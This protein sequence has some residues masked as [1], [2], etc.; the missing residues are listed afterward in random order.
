LN[1]VKR[2]P[3]EPHDEADMPI[4]QEYLGN[5][6][7]ILRSKTLLV[8]TGNA[9][10]LHGFGYLHQCSEPFPIIAFFWQTL[11]YTQQLPLNKMRPNLSAT[12][13][14]LVEG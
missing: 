9:S 2:I 7:A 4:G 1:A 14:I 3:E 12:Y 13:R 10:K 6:R 5:E 8:R 11:R